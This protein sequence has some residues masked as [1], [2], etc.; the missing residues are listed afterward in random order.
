MFAIRLVTLIKR[1][2]EAWF[3]LGNDETGEEE[4]VS[5]RSATSASSLSTGFKPLFSYQPSSQPAPSGRPILRVRI[6][7]PW[8]MPFIDWLGR[9]DRVRLE[10]VRSS[11]S[12]SIYSPSP[13]P[14]HHFSL[15]AHYSDH[16][17]PLH[18]S[19]SNFSPFIRS[20]LSL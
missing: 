16:C 9:G 14:S 18:P 13:G 15:C 3:R 17:Q 11:G 19:G 7:A 6:P 8:K 20:C 1:L 2:Y 4:R 12:P 5:F 10:I